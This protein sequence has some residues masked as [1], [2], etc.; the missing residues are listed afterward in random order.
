[1]RV[2]VSEG[3]RQELRALRRWDAARVVAAIERELS[4]EPTTAT[5][6]KKQ[7]SGSDAVWELR[8]G[9]FRVFYDVTGPVVTILAVRR[10]GRKTTGEIR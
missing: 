9:D 7:L 2:T 3:A 10:K 6:N 5:K 8:V 4:T 1:M